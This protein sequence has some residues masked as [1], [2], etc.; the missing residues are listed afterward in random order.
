V[1]IR[2]WT[3][4][5]ALLCLSG[6]AA[7]QDNA[8]IVGR[9]LEF[10]TDAPVAAVQVELLDSRQRRV[11]EAI[12]DDAGAFRFT[13]VRAGSYQLRARSIG[14]REVTTPAVDSGRRRPP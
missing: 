1:W 14:Y 6:R 10:T 9:V 5:V 11:G 7:A 4:S 2:C 3:V 8:T 13:N 12:T